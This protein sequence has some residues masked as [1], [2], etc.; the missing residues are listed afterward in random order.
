MSARQDVHELEGCLQYES[1][2]ELTLRRSPV[3]DNKI[4]RVLSLKEAI[5]ILIGD[6]SNHESPTRFFHLANN[7]PLI[8]FGGNRSSIS[9]RSDAAC[10]SRRS[11]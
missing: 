10:A 6:E 3:G 8:P 1:H 7:R 5:E 2:G 9:R 4:V 11:S